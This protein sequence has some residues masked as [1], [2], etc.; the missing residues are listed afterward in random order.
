MYWREPST[1]GLAQAVQ[2]A[3][4]AA[5]SNGATQMSGLELARAR[6]LKCETDL[7]A[8]R[9]A[10]RVAA[11]QAGVSLANLFGDCSFTKRET[12]ER[13]ASEAR[14][15]GGEQRVREI[16]RAFSQPPNPALRAWGDKMLRRRRAAGFADDATITA[17]QWNTLL[18]GGEVTATDDLD[19]DAKATADAIIKA[20]ERARSSGEHERP[21]PTGKAKQILDAARKAHRRQG[22]D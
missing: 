21:V 17:D 19:T 15:A 2:M 4:A 18:G 11:K 5:R 22:D 8:A 14:E 1:R 9:E 20:G 10:M 13:W 6:V 3:Q 7:S 12:G 16:V